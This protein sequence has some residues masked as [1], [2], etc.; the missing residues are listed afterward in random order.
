MSAPDAEETSA[1]RVF[2]PASNVNTE[3]REATERLANASVA[4]HLADREFEEA[5]RQYAEARGAARARGLPT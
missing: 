5:M 1:D 3:Y 2:R 4:K